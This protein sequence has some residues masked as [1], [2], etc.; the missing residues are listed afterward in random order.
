MSQLRKVDAPFTTVDN[1]VAEDSTLSYR[2]RGVLLSLLAKPNGWSVRADAIA[3]GGTEGRDAILTA[4]RE[5]GARGHYRIVRY[6]DGGRWKTVTELSHRP[7]QA[8]A[9]EWAASGGGPVLLK[10]NVQVSAENGFPGL[11]ADDATGEPDDPDRDPETGFPASGRPA[12][13]LSAA[14]VKTLSNETEVPSSLRSDGATCDDARLPDLTIIQGGEES[15]RDLNDRAERFLRNW[16]DARRAER[17]EAAMPTQSYI[18]IKKIVTQKLKIRPE[19]LVAAGLN[20]LASEQRAISEGTLQNAMRDAARHPSAPE[21]FKP[22]AGED[23]PE[24]SRRT[25][26]PAYSND[27]IWRGDNDDGGWGT[28][29]LGDT[30]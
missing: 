18:A 23:T 15:P 10:E 17:G 2:A 30:K 19:R 16:W 22:Y 11:G 26:T 24:T 8:W 3:R 12:P 25:R 5:L 9:D 20:I 28:R 27:R 6:R 4:L 7:V 29:A 14:V 13:G 21:E 1:S